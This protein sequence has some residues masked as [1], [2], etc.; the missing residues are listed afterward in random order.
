MHIYVHNSIS[1][2]RQ[3]VE[4][5]QMHPEWQKDKKIS[6]MSIQYNNIVNK[7]RKVLIHTTALMNT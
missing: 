5:T 4:K 6:G 2:N 3:M 7:G 1:H